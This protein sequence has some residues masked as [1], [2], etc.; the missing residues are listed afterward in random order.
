MSHPFDIVYILS[1]SHTFKKH[2]QKIGRFICQKNVRSTKT[3]TNEKS[4][5]NIKKKFKCKNNGSCGR[6]WMISRFLFTYGSHLVSFSPVFFFG[7]VL[8]KLCVRMCFFFLFRWSV[9]RVYLFVYWNS[10]GIFFFISFVLLV[11]HSLRRHQCITYLDMPM[12][13]NQNQN[14]HQAMKC[15]SKMENGIK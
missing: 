7:I 2:E 12:R 6:V 8:N 9:W 15:A 1:A 5:E 13:N 3:A 10:S 11:A 14:V 4:A